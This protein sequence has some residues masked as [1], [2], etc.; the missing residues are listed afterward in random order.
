M[1]SRL[2]LVAC[3]GSALMAADPARGLTPVSAG[4]V[5]WA[6]SFTIQVRGADRQFVELAGKTYILVKPE[7]IS[8]GIG[9][10]QDLA[11]TAKLRKLPGD[12][13]GLYR[14]E[15][16]TVIGTGEALAGKLDGD[17]VHL[18]G[19]LTASAQGRVLTVIKAASAPSDA[20]LLQERLAG[21]GESDWDR[22]LGVVNWC[23]EQ[24]KSAGNADFWTATGDSLL[25]T[26]VVDLCSKAA[27]QKDMALVT[28][29]L[30][31][32]LNRLHDPGL[33]ARVSSPRWIR[34]HGGPQA[35]IL[36]RRMRGLGYSIYKEEWLPRAQA[37]E[38]EYDDR[39]N[40]LGWKDAEGFYRLGRWV[41]DNA[42]A[43]PRARERSWRCYQAG[44]AADPSHAGIAR[45]LGVQP[46][47]A[48]GGGAGQPGGAA[49]TATAQ[50][51]IDLESG[52]RVP[53]PAGWRR[54]QPIGDA[55]V[56]TDPNSDTAYLS[57]RA[58][59][60]PVD[61]EAQIKLLGDEARQR[62]GFIE[63]GLADQTDGSRRTMALRYSWSDGN[64]QRF[65]AI[66]FVSPGEDGP[67]AVIEARGQASEQPSLDRALDSCLSG[68]AYKP[69][70][71]A[72][73]AQ[74]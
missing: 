66:A 20:Q 54:G 41:D 33:A 1:L 35:E 51:F 4:A 62:E 55:S 8:S 5:P 69:T 22:R 15:G 37:L 9:D 48:A 40:G 28:R 23:H 39:Y 3:A 63:I 11:I 17:N 14:V 16:L 29:A 6:P 71:A 47:A 36:A 38:R 50:D 64:Q 70:D 46:Q 42:E 24:A 52:L 53:A 49:S 21:I 25:S 67:A 60:A 57:V 30:D 31:L 32:A 68:T 19:R 65:A 74:P 12:R 27:E 18:L 2:L 72:P 61:R 10:A 44:F 59:R 58:V 13:F 7:E 56:W 43:L 45:E 26:I 73:P 34:D